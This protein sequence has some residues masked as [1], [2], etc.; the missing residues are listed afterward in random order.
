M[1]TKPLVGSQAQ[2]QS[3]RSLNSNITSRP[4]PQRS[5]S[6]TSPTRRHNE[7]LIDLTLDVPDSTSARYG[8]TS[9]AGGSR[10]KQE[11]SNDSRSSVQADESSLAPSNSISNRQSLPSRGRPQLHSDILRMRASKSILL[12][13]QTHSQTPAKP[14]AF[15]VRPGQHPPPSL[16]RPSPSIGPTGKRDAR[17]KPFVLEVPLAAPSYSPNGHADFFPWNGNHAEDQFSEPVIRQGFFDK[18]QMSQNETGSAKASIYPSLKHKSGLQ[19]LSSLFTSVL[20]QRRAHGNI[21]AD[22]TFKPPP[23]VTVTDTKREIWLK[24]LANPTISLRRLSRSIPHGIRGKVLLEHALNKNIPIERAVWLAKCV[25]ANELRSFKRKG[26]GGAFAMGGEAKW[27]RDFTVSVEQ[28]LENIIGSCGEK[29]FRR[30]IYYAIR[31]AA[32]FHAECL[33]DREHYIDWI[34]SSLE[35]TSQAKLPMWLLIA[36]MYWEDILKYRRFGRRFTTVL[37]NRFSETIKHPDAD[38][39]GPLIGRLRIL[40]TKLMTL[41]PDNFVSPE[42]WSKHREVLHAYLSYSDELPI[43]VWDEINRRNMR[44]TTL[45][46]EAQHPP[47]Q[48]LFD[49]LDKSLFA[50]FTPEIID[51]C[52][53]LDDDKTALVHAILDWST[54]CYR[55]GH[56]KVFIGARIIRA[57]RRLGTDTTAVTLSFLDSSACEI[58]RNKASFYH[59]VSELV[60]SNDFCIPT[61]LQWLIS[62]G[63]IHDHS[64]LAPDG[65]CGTRLLAE[66]PI[67]NLSEEMAGLRRSLLYRAE[68]PIDTEDRKVAASISNISNAFRM[69]PI[70]SERRLPQVDRYFRDLDDIQSLN[71]TSKSHIGSW[72]LREVELQMLPSSKPLN[73]W[74]NP[75]PAA[76]DACGLTAAAFVMVRDFLES[77]D[78]FTILAEVIKIA[79]ASADPQT[80]SSCADTLNLHA[81]VFAGIGATK[82]LF[83]VL[84]NRARSFADDRDIMPRAVLGSLLDLSFKMPEHQLLTAQLARQLALSDRKCVADACSPVSDHVAGGSQNNEVEFVDEIEKLL[85]N[86]T[87]IDRGTM[88]RLFQRVTHHLSISLDKSPEQQRKCVS[89]LTTLRDFNPQPFDLL[90]ASWLPY[91]Q[92]SEQRPS[93]VKIWG[94]MIGLGCFSMKDLVDASLKSEKDD[95]NSST[96]VSME[97]LALIATPLSLPEILTSDEAYRVRIVQSRMP[98]DNPE[99]TLTVI[100]SAIEACSAAV[101]NMQPITFQTLNILGS[102]AMHDLLQTLVLVGGD[103]IGRIMVH[104]LL[105]GTA[106]QEASKVLGA[107]INKLLVPTYHIETFDISVG[108]A[109]KSANYL[110]LPFCQL[111]VASTFRS[112]KV[113]QAISRNMVSPHLDD[114]DRAV[115]SAIMAGGTTWACIVPSLDLTAVHHLR[116]GAETQLLRLFHAAKASG[117]Y[118]ILE[119]EH[120]LSKAESLMV[121]LDLTI[122]KIYTEKINTSHSSQS[123]FPEVVTLLN[124]ASQCFASAQPNS[125]KV[126]YLTKWLPLLL[127]FTTSQTV[128]LEPSKVGNEHRGRAI[129]CLTAIFLDLYRF[130]ANTKTQHLPLQQCFDLILNMVD[131]LPDDIR[132]Q[133]SRNFRDTASNPITS[134]I[135]SIMAPPSDWLHIYQSGTKA[136]AAGRNISNTNTDHARD[137]SRQSFPFTMKRWEMLGEPSANMGENDTSLSLTLFASRK[138]VN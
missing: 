42:I 55:P 6:S 113:P 79:T 59:L 73:Q 129:L 106:N 28:V 107:S 60:R 80:I 136:T 18:S 83:D 66:L 99:L 103:M 32:H 26:A 40:L 62:R 43:S 34:L 134:Y 125:C 72:L 29:D 91:I 21:T 133:C 135:Y 90:M 9:R 131:V 96:T 44:L 19:T 81:E 57:W 23:R 70:A 101:H 100:R 64:D 13:D 75:S 78:D 104:P 31:L 95:S 56:A 86:G 84:I 46:P 39:L 2:R 50:L 27:V 8:Q 128:A 63:G 30:R 77:V 10:L 54:S 94:P 14:F 117:Y 105:S 1:T 93:M 38:I 35:T 37:L 115:E 61:Y 108:D 120:Q 97:L 7:A 17:P 119:E 121:I 33:L 118:D 51:I 116:R 85:A 15:P 74:G 5:L 69:M 49:I 98:I 88:E 20:A 52:W 102:S 24:D 127:S 48:R 123:C 87:S 82:D 4:S 45:A 112:G 36:Q 138:G 114:L 68:Y 67:Q 126:T 111:K 3:Q 109:L 11:I 137:S 76:H 122:D 89:L 58:G 25:G 41:N 16:G 12:S 71:R 130:K 110:N 92:K 47:Q 22:S 65:P 132:Q 124:N 53:Q